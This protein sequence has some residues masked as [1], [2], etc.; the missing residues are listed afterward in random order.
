LKDAI[1]F[2]SGCSI[3][4][5]T[6]R[7]SCRCFTTTP[8]EGYPRG[9]EFVGRVSPRSETRRCKGTQ[10]FRQVQAAE[11]V[12]PYVLSG[13]YCLWWWLSPRGPCPPL[14]S[15]GGQVDMEVLVEYKPKSPTE[16]FSGS[17]LP[18]PTSLTTVRVILLHYEYYE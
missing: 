1:E 12:I 13:L 10:G 14:Y 15:L 5:P 3:N 7:A 2:S 8:T 6:W 16:Y 9:G 11:S 4:S 17:F 18:C